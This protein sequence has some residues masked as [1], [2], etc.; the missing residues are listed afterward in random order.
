MDF[1]KLKITEGKF[2]EVNVHWDQT[3]PGR[4]C[5]WYKKDDKKDLLELSKEAILEFYELGKAVKK[6]LE[7][8][9]N[10]DLFN[11]YS[12]SN[13]T[14][15]LHIHL[16]PRYSRERKLFGLTF[17]DSNF[18]KGYERDHNFIVP[19]EI[20]FRIKDEIVKNL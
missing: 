1:Q 4:V 6:S 12:L 19:E 2:W 8:S 3:V 18:G 9:F 13:A 14:K 15:H 11:Y 20:L 16:I 17:K 10:P 7:K 5:F